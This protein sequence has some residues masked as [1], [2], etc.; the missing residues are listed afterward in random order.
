[1]TS[2]RTCPARNLKTI[3]ADGTTLSNCRSLRV[4]T[5]GN[6]SWTN[7]DGTTESAVPVTAGELL[8][9]QPLNILASGTPATVMG[10]FD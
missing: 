2:D 5:A 3:A 9:F 1:M 10:Y 4:K 7:Q 6:L 8:N